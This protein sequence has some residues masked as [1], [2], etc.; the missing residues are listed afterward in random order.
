MIMRRENAE[1]EMIFAIFFASWVILE[2]FLCRNIISRFVSIYFLQDLS[3]LRPFARTDHTAFLEHIHEPRRPGIA[4]FQFSLE[5]GSGCLACFDD[6]S[7]RF[8]IHLVIGLG[9]VD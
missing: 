6:A 4:Q 9:I 7:A 3:G 1:I 2:S 5:I 8:L